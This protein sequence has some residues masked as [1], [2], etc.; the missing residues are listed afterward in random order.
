M[1][2]LNRRRFLA[3][4]L[5]M[6][7][8]ATAAV[9]PATAQRALD[10]R[11]TIDATHFG[12]TPGALDDQSRRFQSMLDRAA[13]GNEPVFL[14]PGN[15]I[16]SN[17]NLPK[18]ISLRGIPGETRFIY[19]GEGH[20]L[21]SDG[22]DQVRLAGIT[23]DGGNRGLAD[24]SRGL[25]ELRGTGKFVFDDCEIFGSSKHNIVLERCGGRIERSTLSGALDAAIYAVESRDLAISSNTIQDCGNGGILVHRWQSGDDGT[26]VTGNRIRRIGAR[27]GGTGQNGN[28]INVFR[29]NGVMIANNEVADCA[30]SAIRSNSGSNLQINGNRCLRSGETAI[31][32]EFKFEGAVITGNVVDGAANGISMVNFNDGGRM[33]VCSGNL[34]RNLSTKGPYPAD[35]PG[36]GVGITAEADTSVTGNVIE[37]APRYGIHLGWGKYLRNVIANGNVLRDC[38]TGIAVSVVDGAGPAVVSDNII[39][40]AKSGNVIGYEWVNP[41]TRD[42]AKSANSAPKNVT[43]QRNHVS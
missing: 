14:P 17:I 38:K 13:H 41:V 7:I 19:S 23:I 4:V 30:F 39:S 31:Y 25:I 26:Q 42:L 35:A 10:L 9:C 43:V 33:A 11:G 22:S 40:G 21:S 27:S 24:Y 6:G 3:G 8:G 34:V 36:F 1:P 16:I 18:R 2:M 29:A 20:L 28:G 37:N 5:P 12:I 15:Y 32:S